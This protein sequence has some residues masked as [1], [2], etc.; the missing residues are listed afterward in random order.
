MRDQEFRKE[1]EQILN[2]VFGP[3]EE[4]KS[5]KLEP[6]LEYFKEKPKNTPTK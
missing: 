6:T 3:K 2:E 4:E 5:T 1:V